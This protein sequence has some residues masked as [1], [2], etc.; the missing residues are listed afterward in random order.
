M[1]IDAGVRID[2][3]LPQQHSLKHYR[4]M[5]ELFGSPNG[6]CSSITESKHIVAVKKPWRCSSRYLCLGQML[7]RISR[8]EKPPAARREFTKQGMMEGSTYSYTAMLLEGGAPEPPAL[9][10]NSDME[11]EDK[12]LGPSCG[13]KVLSSIS[14]AK[15]SGACIHDSNPFLF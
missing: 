11:D 4:R 9:E 7:L 12:D 15:T 10:D 2:I 6:L 8:E 1:F 5:I 3:S 13:P 14:L